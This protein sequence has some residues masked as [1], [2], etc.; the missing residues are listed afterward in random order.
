MVQNESSNKMSQSNLTSLFGPT[1]MTV[2]GDPVSLLL[3]RKYNVQGF[4]IMD[5]YYSLKPGFHVT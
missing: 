4:V 5:C 3:V 1:L 2:D